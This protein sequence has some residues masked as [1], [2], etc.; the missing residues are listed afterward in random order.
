[1]YDTQNSY[2]DF[3][4][5]KEDGWVLVHDAIP[6]VNIEVEAIGRNYCAKDIFIG[7][8]S[9]DPTQGWKGMKWVYAWREKRESNIM[10]ELR[11]QYPATFF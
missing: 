7:L 9:F 8:A 3:K 1:M 10:Q 5:K 11:E 4:N 6:S 2:K